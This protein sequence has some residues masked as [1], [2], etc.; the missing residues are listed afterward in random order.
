MEVNGHFRARF[1]LTSVERS[2]LTTG[3]ASESRTLAVLKYAVILLINLLLCL[4]IRNEDEM[5]MHVQP[6]C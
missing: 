5:F 6:Q 4:I 1:A 2:P 3:Y